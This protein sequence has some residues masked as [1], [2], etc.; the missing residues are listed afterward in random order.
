MAD[1]VESGA[2]TFSDA[3][4]QDWTAR[5]ASPAPQTW[6]ALARA[7]MRRAHR[8]LAASGAFISLEGSFHGKTGGA[9]A[10]THG[11]HY[12]QPF[13]VADTQVHFIDPFAP[14]AADQLCKLIDARCQDLVLPL[15]VDGELHLTA[16]RTCS[17]AALFFE[18]VQGEGGIRT[19]PVEFLRFVR[20]RADDHGFALVADEIQTG[21]GRTGRFFATDHAGVSADCYLLSKSLGGGLTKIGALLVRADRYQSEFGLLHSS[22]FAEDEHSAEV[23]LAALDLLRD[24]GLSETAA[25]RGSEILAGLEALCQRYPHAFVAARGRGLLLGVSSAQS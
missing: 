18:P 10:L 20:E 5:F 25:K 3:V 7:L 12:R 8:T 6:P 23:A 16:E 11:E 9:L 14:D 1:R 2:V 17:L 19:L 13:R 4:R 15:A 24:E 21:M 22:T